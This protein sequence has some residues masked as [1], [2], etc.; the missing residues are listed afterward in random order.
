MNI[1]EIKEKFLAWKKL[2]KL[3][4]IKQDKEDKFLFKIYL[5]LSEKKDVD[6]EE[7]VR[8]KDKED[9]NNN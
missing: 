4:I 5:F 1:K 9:V 7:L 2:H 6:W 3:I 8:E